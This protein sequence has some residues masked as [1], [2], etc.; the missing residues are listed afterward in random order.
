[1]PRVS[2]RARER[3][4]TLAARAGVE[5]QLRRA[6]HLVNRTARREAR[7]NEHLTV[8]LAATLAPDAMCIDV[9]AHDGGVLRE[10]VRC[11]PQGR[12]IAYE[13]LPELAAA[14]ARDYPQVDVRNAALSD[15]DGEATFLHDRT[16]PMRSTLHAHAFTDHANATE[17]KVRVERLDSA[18]PPD[19][20][21]SLIKIDVEGTEAE[22]LRGAVETLRR[23]RPVVV[24]EH[25]AGGTSSPGDVHSILVEVAGYRIFDLDGMGPY[26][27][28]EFEATYPRPTMWNWIARP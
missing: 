23:H 12:H 9:G 1:M 14:L 5:S 15:H 10:I 18:L 4:R 8:L 11:A 22:V 26:S 16:E 28:E 6:Y 13:P 20:V 24:F 27:L 19:Y 3:V 7:D 25:G 21:P 2:A 17:I